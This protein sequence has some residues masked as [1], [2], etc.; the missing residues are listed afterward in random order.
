MATYISQVTLFD[1]RTVRR[2][3]GVLIEDGRIEW[4][5]AHPRRPRAARGAEAVEGRGRTLTPGLF[6][7]HVHLC[8]DGEANFVDE[9]RVSETTAALKAVRNA[10]RHL[11]AGVTTVRDLGSIG[12]VACDVARAIEEGIVR[13]PRVI[14]SGQAITITG[15]HGWNTFGVQADGAPAIRTA[16]R[17]QV[18]A[19]ARSIKI[20]A[21][22]GVLTP[23]IAF[24]FTA[25]TL[26]EVEA[27]VEE[28]HR[29]KVPITAHAIGRQGIRHCV[30][31][32]IDS[33]EH[34]AQIDQAIARQ[35]KSKGI[36]HVP[37]ISAL[38]GIVGH[39]DQVPDYAVAKGRAVME[40][41]QQAFAVGLRNGVRY[42]CGTDAGT[43]FNPHGGGP[44]ELLRMIEWGL[45]PV[46]A[47]EAA[48]ANAAELLRLPDVGTVEK[49]KAADLVL[50]PGDPLEDPEILLFPAAVWRTGELVAGG[51]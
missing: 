22:G 20:V 15:G 50:W 44:R 6:D 23:G 5:G 39:P 30:R 17:K 11:A 3:A 48:T 7:C 2:S 9:G 33:V 42:V 16:I 1:G 37:T 32:G 18:R 12:V 21:T 38:D 49:G 41:A 35:M 14:P 47:L 46:K 36:F 29:W 34:G 27:A 13:G 10:E 19:G 28:A 51:A 26:D 43:P 8:F 25:F 4:V 31:A 40:L 45:P 24:D